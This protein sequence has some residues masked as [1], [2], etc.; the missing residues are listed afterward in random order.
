MKVLL[1]ADEQ[2]ETG[3]ETTI[4]KGTALNIYR[5]DGDSTVDVIDKQGRIYRLFVEYDESAYWYE[6]IGGQDIEDLFE[7]L[8]FAG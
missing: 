4:V 8:Y 3:T 2:D 1:L 5:T 7:G 6:S